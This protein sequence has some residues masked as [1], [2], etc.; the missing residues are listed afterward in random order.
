MTVEET[1]IQTMVDTVTYVS[2]ATATDFVTA[3]VT[4][5]Y[6]STIVQPTTYVS[7]VV[8]TYVINNV[9][10]LSHA[11]FDLILI[12]PTCRPRLSLTP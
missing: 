9:S 8:S 2:T 1:Q 12:G 4:S 11:P 10:I 3:T 7:A 6:V 5:V